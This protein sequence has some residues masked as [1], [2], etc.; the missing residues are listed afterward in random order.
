MNSANVTK[1]S[2]RNCLNLV[3]AQVTDYKVFDKS[4]MFVHVVIFETHADIH[5]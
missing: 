3:I 5:C 2:I 4:L 1:S